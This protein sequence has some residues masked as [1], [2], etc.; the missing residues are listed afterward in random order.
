MREPGCLV[1]DGIGKRKII[2]ADDG[3]TSPVVTTENTGAVGNKKGTGRR[4]AGI[5]NKK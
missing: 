3:P 2:A 5:E 1:V 4:K